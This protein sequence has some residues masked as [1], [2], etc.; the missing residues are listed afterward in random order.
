MRKNILKK[1]ITKPT[2]LIESFIE[3][4]SIIEDLKRKID[5]KIGPLSYKTNVRGEMS[6][7]QDFLSEDSFRNVMR[8]NENLWTSEYE[9]IGSYILVEAWGNKLKKNDFIEEH[10]HEPSVL[11]GIIY[12]TNNGP[13]TYFPEINHTITE[14]IGKTVLFESRL[15]HSVSKFTID[16]FRY[17]ISFNLDL[18]PNNFEK[19]NKKYGNI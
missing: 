13:G 4:V 1:L 15:K 17:T 19:I 3:D 9:E 18:P 14:E 6:N 2:T 10:S 16:E 11:S 7:W 8:Q 12:L 5:K